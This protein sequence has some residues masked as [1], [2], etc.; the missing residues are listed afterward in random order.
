[1][2]DEFALALFLKELVLGCRERFI[3]RNYIQRGLSPKCSMAASSTHKLS[4]LPSPGTAVNVSDKVN[5]TS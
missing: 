2:V 4:G 5:C 3:Y 1:M